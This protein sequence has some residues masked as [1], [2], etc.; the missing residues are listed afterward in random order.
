MID[1]K[2]ISVAL[3]KE[4]RAAPYAAA[5]RECR[6]PPDQI[7]FLLRQAL[8]IANEQPMAPTVKTQNDAGGHIHQE[9]TTS[10][11]PS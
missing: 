1:V 7:L 6:R 8:G 3:T 11:V 4:E 10:A 5:T 9:L 2:T